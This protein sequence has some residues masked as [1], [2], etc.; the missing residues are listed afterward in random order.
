MGKEKLT[1]QKALDEIK[2]IVSQ[3]ENQ[4]ITIDN[5][6]EKIKRVSFLI[7]FCKKNLYKTET[8]IN[9][10]LDIEKNE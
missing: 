7:E 8:E 3:I 5:L 1:Y 10:L 6:T 4:D 9:K 2:D